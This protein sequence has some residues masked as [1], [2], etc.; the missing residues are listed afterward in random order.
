MS[1]SRA[2]EAKLGKLP[3]FVI[4][5]VLEWVV[6]LLLFVDGFL[7]FICNEF[8][9]LF[10]LPTPCLLC[11]RIDHMLV[12][13]TPNFYYN[14]SICDDHKKDLSSLAYCNLHRHLSDI[15]T[16][17][18]GCLISF[19]NFDKYTSLVGTSRINFKKERNFF[20]E[21]DR[22]FVVHKDDAEIAPGNNK[23]AIAVI[24]CSCC[25]EPLK[26][27]SA[28]SKHK[29]SFSTNAPASSPRALSSLSLGRNDDE[30]NVD[31]PPFRYTELKLVADSELELPEDED[32]SRA[33]T[34]GKSDVK[35]APVAL[36]PDSEDIS[37]FTART[38]STRI[39]KFFGIPLSDSAQMSPRWAGRNNKRQSFE[40]LDLI[41]EANDA[42]DAAA[43]GDILTLLK[44]QIR[45]D[46]KALS[47]L[48]MELDEERSASAVAANNAMA[49]ISRLQAEKAAVQ[50]EALQYQRMSEE[51]AEYDQEALEMMKEILFKREEEIKALE[52]ELEMYRENYGHSKRL[53]V[54]EICDEVDTDNYQDNIKSP[55]FSTLSDKSEDRNEHEREHKHEREPERTFDRF[56]QK[57]INAPSSESSEPAKVVVENQNCASTDEDEGSGSLAKEVSMISE[58]LRAQHNLRKIRNNNVESP[59]HS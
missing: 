9:R 13:R 1:L 20:V 11:T 4:Y 56:D 45:L 3:H 48:Q 31:L 32:A 15:R 5:A 17:C 51:Q 42:R 18:H 23:G 2:V 55:T 12:H 46:R 54:G 27:K 35:T 30:G 39:N 57:I 21:D 34:R 25:R 16:M 49:M 50:M 36:L 43:D 44:R 22:K 59:S 38:P 47:A 10:D 53:I 24:R 14:N 19:P 8:A 28:S 29:R 37:D 41:M 7:A 58:R 33:D 40:R 52:S 6:I 26:P